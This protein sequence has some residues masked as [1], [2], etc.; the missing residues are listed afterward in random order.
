MPAH[1]IRATGLV[2][3]SDTGKFKVLLDTG[4][5][6]TQA[7]ETENFED[8]AKFLNSFR[9]KLAKRGLAW[10]WDVTDQV[11]DY[12]EDVGQLHDEIEKGA[13]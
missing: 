1:P 2:W 3:M 10:N 4:P 13:P 9:G 5:D 8:M 11:F 7:F 12:T 6:K